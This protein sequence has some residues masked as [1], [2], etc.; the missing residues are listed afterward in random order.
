MV[1]RD[2]CCDF[3]GVPDQETKNELILAIPERDRCRNARAAAWSMN[4]ARA[5]RDMRPRP[6]RHRRRS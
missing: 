3:F 4:N 6:T 2:F 5:I 1:A